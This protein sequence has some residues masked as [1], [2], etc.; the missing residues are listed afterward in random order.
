MPP[1]MVRKRRVAPSPSTKPARAKNAPVVVVVAAAAS[2]AEAVVAVDLVEAAAVVEAAATVVV[3]DVVN[4]GAVAAIAS[5][6]MRALKL[7]AFK[8]SPLGGGLLCAGRF[9]RPDDLNARL[10]LVQCIEV[11]PIRAV[12]K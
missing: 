10:A 11:Q 2:E 4:V 6:R 8:P 1:S 12:S 3:A 5:N 9:Q 7:S